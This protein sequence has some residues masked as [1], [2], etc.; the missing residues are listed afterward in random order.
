MKKSIDVRTFLL[1]SNI[2]GIITPL[3]KLIENSNVEFMAIGKPIR[4][5]VIS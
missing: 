2:L 3:K 4:E 1:F 5:K